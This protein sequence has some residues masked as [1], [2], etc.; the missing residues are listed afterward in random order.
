MVLKS[1]EFPSALVEVAFINNPYEASLLKNPA[2]QKQM[3]RQLATGVKT[4]LQRAGLDRPAGGVQE[5][6]GF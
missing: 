2:F 1:V 5:D 6:G 4:Y 3:A